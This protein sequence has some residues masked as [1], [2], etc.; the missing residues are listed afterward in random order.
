MSKMKEMF[1]KKEN[2][3]KE[4]LKAYYTNREVFNYKSIPLYDL[5]NLITELEEQIKI[6]F[7]TKEEFT[8]LQLYIENSISIDTLLNNKNTL[9]INIIKDMEGQ[10]KKAQYKYIESI[11]N[12]LKISNITNYIE[13]TVT[14]WK[15][16]YKEFGCKNVEEL[17]DYA[18]NTIEKDDE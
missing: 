14:N 7:L 2:L 6:E 1:I 3:I 16:E 15:I 5:E 12:I 11:F 4:G 18:M 8:N 10:L 17:V 9:E 13:E